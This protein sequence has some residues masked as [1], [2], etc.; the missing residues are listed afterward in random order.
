[1]PEA[2]IDEYSDPLANEDNVGSN[3]PILQ[4]KPWVLAEPVSPSMQCCPKCDFGAAVGL[5]VP[6]HY[7]GGRC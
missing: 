4:D 3:S 1:V 6:L 2:S 7:G 5:P